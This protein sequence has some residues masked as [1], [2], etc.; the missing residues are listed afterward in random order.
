MMVMVSMRP[1]SHS[2]KEVT[3]RPEDGAMQIFSVEL[4]EFLIR[5]G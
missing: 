4:S 1:A 2:A 5:R 3:P